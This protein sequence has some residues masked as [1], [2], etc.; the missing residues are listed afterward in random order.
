MM[1]TI[2]QHMCEKLHEI[3]PIQGFD[4]QDVWA[5]NLGVELDGLR[6][7]PHMARAFLGTVR[8]WVE[9]RVRVEFYLRDIDPHVVRKDDLDVRLWTDVNDLGFIDERG[10]YHSAFGRKLPMRLVADAQGRPVLLGNNL[11]F[12]SEPVRIERTGVFHYTAEFSADD[13][14]V[15]DPSKAW[16]SVNDIAHNQDGVMVI[17]PE[18]VRRCPSVTEVCVRKVGAKREG[19][20]F[21]SGTFRDVEAMLEEMPTDVIYLL[22]FF[23]PG[24]KD[25]FTGEDVRK[26]TLGSV[27]AVR[28]FFRIDPALV[29]PVEEVDLMSLVSQGLIRDYD[30]SD[31]LDGRQ[32]ARLRRVDDFN[33]F[34]TNKEAIEWIGRDRLVQ[35]VGRAE[36]RALAQRAHVLGKQVIFDLVLMQTSRDCPLIEQ[37]PEWYVL[38]EAGRP[39][40][41]QIAWL[42]YSDVAL[43]DL[44][45]NKSL[46]NY[47]SG[48]ASFWM[49]TCDLDGVRID[50]SQTVDRPFLK[51]IKNRINQV[52]SDA[53]VLGET[54]CALEE[55]VDV[56]VDM[57]YALL[58]DFHRD[59]EYAGPYTGFLEQTFG[60]F[61]PR[62]VAMAY[63]EN[64][65]SARAT[66]VWRERFG[67]W[68]AE[69]EILRE[70]WNARVGGADAAVVMALLRNLQASVIDLTAGTT[71]CVNLAYALEL[72]TTWGEEA[73]TDFENSTFL[74][75]E[76][77]EQEPHSCL[78]AAYRVL[79]DLKDDLPEILDGHIYFHRSGFEGGDPADR[80]LAYV[81][82]TSSSGL[83]AVHNLDPAHA[84]QVRIKMSGLPEVRW[85]NV[86][87]ETLFDTYKFFFKAEEGRVEVDG[88]A[89]LV[90]VAPLQSLLIRIRSVK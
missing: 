86:K 71:R 18:R 8:S 54:L 44:K 37:H 13:K 5:G 63:F 17:S 87:V 48:V 40:I 67:G 35:M 83:L 24:F 38:D 50:A 72:G 73:R 39:K 61:A 62:T 19:E 59:V 28:D 3:Y 4:N 11:V 78:V 16:V 74:H 56:P 90:S 66:R 30:L 49:K 82:F 76:R 34:S 27:Y 65:D 33:N 89:V 12:E 53:I 26:G 10:A 75:P 70:A 60:A 29:S 77:A 68:L 84:R 52:K 21:E 47:L 42:V 46:Q 6:F 2:R 64:H 57:V 32:M 31:L 41:H 9:A 79:H 22:P 14:P 1:K 7:D 80:V 55:A 43:L 23:E 69:Q 58:V 51:Q 45:F 25:A 36:L 81:R 20:A 15:C 88:D 85:G